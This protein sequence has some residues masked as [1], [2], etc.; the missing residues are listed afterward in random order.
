MTR[1]QMFWIVRSLRE[2]ARSKKSDELADLLA[3]IAEHEPEWVVDEVGEFL[4]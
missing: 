1:E 3:S 2:R 4:R